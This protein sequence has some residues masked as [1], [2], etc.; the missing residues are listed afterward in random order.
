MSSTESSFDTGKMAKYRRANG[1]FGLSGITDKS[2]SDDDDDDDD[3]LP[4]G[5]YALSLFSVCEVCS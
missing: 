5:Q 1:S 2:D 4:V 3:D